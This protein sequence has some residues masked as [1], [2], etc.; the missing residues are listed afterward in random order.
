M[1]NKARIGLIVA[2]IAVA[3]AAFVI[4]S[5]GDDE[6]GDTADTATA[7][8]QAET[9]AKTAAPPVVLPSVI[10]LK[11][12]KP[13]GGKAHITARKGDRLRI[14]VISDVDDSIHLHGYDVKKE[15]KPGKPA[16]FDL[17]ATIEGNFEIESH[18]AE[19]AGLPPEIATVT[20]NPS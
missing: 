20:V 18:T 3:V 9:S 14:E 5:N 7:T 10:R 6:G 1:S 19:H 17:K 11:N 4:A 16:V 8:T 12:H 13:V 2:A 15:A